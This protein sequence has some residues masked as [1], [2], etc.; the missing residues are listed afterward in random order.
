VLIKSDLR[1]VSGVL[2]LSRATTR[3]IKQ[4]LFW[5]LAYNT[6][7]IPVAASG[8]LNP[9]F[10]GVAMALN[11]VSVVANSLSLSLTSA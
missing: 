3:K 2:R 10:A 6:V 4:N 5:A 1:D 11:S 9:V 7:L 8:F